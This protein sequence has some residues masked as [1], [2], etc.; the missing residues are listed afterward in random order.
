M[1]KKEKQ[2]KSKKEKITLEYLYKTYSFLKTSWDPKKDLMVF[3]IMCWDGWL[4]LIDE[5]C[6][7]IQE[8]LDNWNIKE[9]MITEIKEKFGWLRFYWYWFNDR[10][11]DKIQEMEEK[12]IKTCE[13]CWKRWKTIWESWYQT[14]CKE[15]AKI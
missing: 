11:D 7:T 4:W 2:T 6:K 5:I 12:S 10:I 9:V 8:E 15:H 13:V 14:L 3:W 1:E